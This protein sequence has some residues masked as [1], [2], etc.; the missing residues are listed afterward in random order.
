MKVSRLKAIAEDAAFWLLVLLASALVVTVFSLYARSPMDGY[1]KV[2]QWNT[3]LRVTGRMTPEAAG[4]ETGDRI[5]SINGTPIHERRVRPIREFFREFDAPSRSAVYEVE[6]NGQRLEVEV[7]LRPLGPMGLI[8]Q[9]GFHFFVS[10]VFIIT[11]AIIFL[12][13]GSAA[14]AAKTNSYN[15][16]SV[17]VICYA[18][19]IGATTITLAIDLS[20]RSGGEWLGALLFITPVT[21]SLAFGLLLHF[22][23]IF[24]PRENLFTRKRW[25]L[26]L[27]HAV[28][29]SPAVFT[30]ALFAFK[31]QSPAGLRQA[32]VAMIGLSIVL[33]IFFAFRNFR[34][35]AS[36]VQKNQIRWLAWGAAVGVGPWLVLYLIPSLLG[37]HRII[38]HRF[39]LLTHTAIPVGVLVAISRYRLLGING[40]IRRSLVYTITMAAMTGVYI[41]SFL[42]IL[43]I[44]ESG[45]SQANPVTGAIVSSVLLVL[46]FK[47][48]KSL[49]DHLVTRMFYRG[50]INTRKA[51]SELSLSISQIIQL[52]QLV[53]LLVTEVPRAFACSGAAMIVIKAKNDYQIFASSNSLYASTTEKSNDLVQQ[54]KSKTELWASTIYPEVEDEANTISLPRGASLC[55]PLAVG[56]RLAGIYLLGEKLSRNLF[57]REEIDRLRT[58]AH[59][60]ASALENAVAYQRLREL[61]AELESMTELRTRQLQQANQELGRKNTDLLKQNSELGRVVNDLRETQAA[62]LEAERRAAIGEIIVTVCHEINNPLTAIMGQAQLIE[63]RPEGLPPE[64]IEKIRIIDESAERIRQ[65]TDKMRNLR[66]SQTTSY[67]GQQR[68][69]ALPSSLSSQESLESLSSPESPENLASAG[70]SSAEVASFPKSS[71]A[72]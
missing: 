66:D 61:N 57:D 48:L 18:L 53:E 26:Y 40:L 36:A 4:L 14:Q 42:A 6:R 29:L 8:I 24:P 25:T 49:S 3:S 20:V 47:P 19:I 15:L 46:A 65:I 63:M 30:S 21:T 54:V 71:K 27:M 60:T 68:M 45:D 72:S 50:A 34:R 13:S 55:F 12:R 23:L 32:R 38:D 39:L 11:A 28:N 67:V 59:H 58:L 35:V 5:I 7:P 33:S 51:F 16:H 22:F 17:R 9:G 44:I 52:P 43:W 10:L 69:I 41:A 37:M 56:G 1:T 70:I 64:I 62:L 31:G 2:G